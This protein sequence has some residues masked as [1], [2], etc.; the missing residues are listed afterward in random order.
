MIKKDEVWVGSINSENELEDSSSA[1]KWIVN[2]SKEYMKTIFPKINRLVNMGRVYR[3][4]YSHKE[5]KDEDPLQYHE[6]VLCVY[7]DDKTKTKTLEEI[8]KLGIIP[9]KWKYEYEIRA[10]WQQGGQLYEE[11]QKEK[12]RLIFETLSDSIY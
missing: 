7:A 10:D 5:N 11:S 2:G 12:L 1:G 8:M 6:P 9:A 4:K 3:A